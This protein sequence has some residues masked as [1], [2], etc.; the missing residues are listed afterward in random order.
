MTYSTYMRVKISSVVEG[1]AD[2]INAI[3]NYPEESNHAQLVRD[4]VY[5][6][7]GSR[8]LFGGPGS[9]EA[10]RPSDDQV[11]FLKAF[12]LGFVRRRA[13]FVIAAFNWWYRCVGVAS[14]P[15]RDDLDDGKAILY[16][17]IEDLDALGVLRLPADALP[18]DLRQA[19]Q[20]QR[21]LRDLFGQAPMAEF[22]TEH[23]SIDG[24]AYASEHAA[25]LAELFTE[26][27]AF[28]GEQLPPI[29]PHLLGRLS[30]LTAQWAEPRRRDLVVRYLGFPIWDVLLYPIQSLTQIGEGDDIDVVRFSPSESTQLPAPDGKPLEGVKLGHFGAFF[31]REARE[32]D[33]L[34]GRLDAAEQLTRLLISST[35]SSRPLNEACKP[36]FE[37][38]LDEDA[39]DLGHITTK[40]AA[41]RQ[42]VSAL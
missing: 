3:C 5:A 38:I 10:Y 39:P 35:E 13:R 21:K 7:A 27:Q 12:D 16:D 22:L 6:W 30:E 40:V 18:S 33:Y 26:L 23:K 34:R 15:S 1:I 19:E 36:L 9:E 11:A 17:A 32:N 24:G 37:A 28:F 25:E 8:G 20:L 42:Q 41:I 31:S 29:A 14:F 2:A 4:T